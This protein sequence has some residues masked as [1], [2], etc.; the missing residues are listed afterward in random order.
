[1]QISSV[2]SADNYV[3]W[4]KIPKGTVSDDLLTYGI[5]NGLIYTMSSM[6]HKYYQIYMDWY[7][8]IFPDVFITNILQRYTLN[9]NSNNNVSKMIA[10]ANWN[11][12]RNRKNALNKLK[13]LSFVR[14][15][16]WAIEFSKYKRTKTKIHRK[17]EWNGKR[18]KKRRINWPHVK[19][20]GDKTSKIYEYYSNK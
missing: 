19:G 3:A 11:W 6:C 4:W 14:S 13:G 2:C 9:K 20:G 10:C 8:Y 12:L 16:K 5:S 1:M 17:F 15:Q 18:I 7:M